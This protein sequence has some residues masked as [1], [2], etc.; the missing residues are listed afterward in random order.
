MNDP[1]TPKEEL[2]KIQ[3]KSLIGKLE[4]TCRNRELFLSCMHGTKKL[5]SFLDEGDDPNTRMEYGDFTLL[6][7]ASMIGNICSAKTLLEY[8]IRIND[9]DRYN[10]TALLWTCLYGRKRLVKLLIEM[11]LIFM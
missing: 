6:I 9:K 10:M 5:R 8:N 1:I 7:I 11:G 4:K 3:K 2:K